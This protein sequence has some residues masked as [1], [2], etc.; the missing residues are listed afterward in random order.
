[1]WTFSVETLA[2]RSDLRMSSIEL[3]HWPDFREP[4]VFVQNMM[5]GKHKGTKEA[6][7]GVCLQQRHMTRF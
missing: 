6:T 2:V 1:M 3:P 4:A 5:D 7:L